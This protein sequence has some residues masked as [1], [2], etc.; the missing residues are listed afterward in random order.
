MRI[1]GRLFLILLLI[2]AAG[3]GFLFWCG[4]KLDA[5]SKAYA[6]TAVPAIVANWSK[7]ELAVR[8]S[9]ELKESVRTTDVSG[10]LASFSQRLGQLV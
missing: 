1:L 5:E 7:Q 3:V 2:V 8:A 4:P 10:L 9:P 6:D